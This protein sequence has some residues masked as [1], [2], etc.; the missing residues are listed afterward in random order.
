MALRFRGTKVDFGIYLMSL[1]FNRMQVSYLCVQMYSE[2][3]L[4]DVCENEF[5]NTIHTC[6]GIRN[7]TVGMF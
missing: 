6:C 5:L 1:T 3:F 7:L 2:I 4:P